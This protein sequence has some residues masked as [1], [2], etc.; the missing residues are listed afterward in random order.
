M[1]VIIHDWKSYFS[2]EEKIGILLNEEKDQLEQKRKWKKTEK[3]MKDDKYSKIFPYNIIY[4]I[5][6]RKI[7]KILWLKIVFWNK[8]R[9]WIF[10]GLA[11]VRKNTIQNEKSSHA[12]VHYWMSNIKEKQTKRMKEIQFNQF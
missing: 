10:K 4:K 3:K 6:I 7:K 1:D 8:N 12:L 11:C 2:V 5:N 9:I